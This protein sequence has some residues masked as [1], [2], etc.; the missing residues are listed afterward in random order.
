MLF[1]GY[2]FL[3]LFVGVVISEF[4]RQSEKLGKNFLLTDQQKNWIEV[5][6]MLTHAKPKRL[7]QVP[8]NPVRKLFWRFVQ[9]PDYQT[10]EK[11]WTICGHKLPDAFDAFIMFTI[12]VN[13]FILCLKWP[14]MSSKTL[15]VIDICNYVCAG[16][17][18]IEALIKL[19]AMGPHYFRDGWN[20]FDFVIVIGS[21]SLI[22]P[23][24][25]KQKNTITMIR[26]FRVGR[27]FK[28]FSKLK[29]LQSIF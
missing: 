6:L 26:A 29:Q 9:T 7:N 27:V 3:N 13:T 14:N 25:K 17:F 24:F 2:F 8:T 23:R 4:N 12:I 10:D 21:V 19:I 22:H 28:L 11:E 18:I 5:K 20:I 1:G 16:I 15:Q